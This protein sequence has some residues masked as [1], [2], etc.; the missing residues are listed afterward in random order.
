[1][2]KI[3]TCLSIAACTTLGYAQG[4]ER[5]YDSEQDYKQQVEARDP[6]SG[7][8]EG[9]DAPAAP[10]DSYLPFLLAAGLGL[11]AWYARRKPAQAS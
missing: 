5:F 6:G 9:D 7:G 1:M 4:S 2:K 8:L 3:W 11:A 10:I